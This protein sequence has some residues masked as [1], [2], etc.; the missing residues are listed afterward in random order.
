MGGFESQIPGGDQPRDESIGEANR[1]WASWLKSLFA[2]FGVKMYPFE[3]EGLAKAFGA[4][5]R[6]W[7]SL[8][9]WKAPKK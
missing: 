5:I 3:E 7:P 6:R 1:R 9:K 4:F 2:I 8:G